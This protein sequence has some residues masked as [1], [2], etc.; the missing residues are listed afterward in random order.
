[1]R[2]QSGFEPSDAL[3]INVNLSYNKAKSDGGPQDLSIWDMRPDLNYQGNYADWLSDLLQAAG[4]PRLEIF[5]DPRVVLDDYTM[6][7]WCFIDDADPDWDQLCEQYNNSE[8]TQ[9]DVDV[10]M[11]AQRSFDADVDHRHLAVRERIRSR[12]RSCSASLRAPGGVESDVLYQELQVNATLGQ[13]RVNL[14]GGLTYFHEEGSSPDQASRTVIGTSVF[15][16]TPGTPPNA[17]AGLRSTNIGSTQPESDSYGLFLNAGISVTEKFR[18]TPGVRWAYDQQDITQIA[19]R[20]DNFIPFVGDSTTIHATDDWNEVDW[21]LTFDRTLGENHMIYVTASKAYRAGAY[22]LPGGIPQ[23]RTGGQIDA[24][25]AVTPPFT[26][27]ENVRNNEIGLRTEWLDNRLRLN[28]TYF[29]MAYTDRQGARAQLDPTQPAGF[30][31]VVVNTG[32]V[33]VWGTEFEGQFAVN[34]S[35][36]LDFSAGNVN[37]RLHD[38]CQNNGDYFFP[39]PV[40]DSYSVGSRWLK[41]L[42]SGSSLTFSLSYAHTGEQQ[43]HPG[44]TLDPACPVTAQYF[45]DSRY[46][47]DDYGLWNARVRYDNSNGRWTGSLYVNNLTDEVYANNSSRAG[48]G[49]WDS[50]NRDLGCPGACIAV[51]ERSV[52]QQ[53]RGRP[54][55]Y[56]VTFQY[57]FGGLGAGR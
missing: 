55:E 26:P 45:L 47:N 36:T 13:D 15:P 5:N 32:D 2:L 33:D 17:W 34:D 4:Q 23:N 41:P 14:V 20:S 16:A 39:G 44:G 42:S 30:F 53:V 9:L 3:T 35:V 21:R 57:N 43:T 6:P 29:D 48:G 38:I 12:I 1:M 54:R 19:Y 11:A 37:T 51:P 49:F 7:D 52:V 50:G 18:I 25:L 24:T 8:F 27:P 31:I 56:G 28:W 10:R 46:V 22:T 40:E